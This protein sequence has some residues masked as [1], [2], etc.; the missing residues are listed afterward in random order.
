[1]ALFNN[2][3]LEEFL[4]FIRNCSTNLDLSGILEPGA[5]IQY[6][7]TMVHGESLRQFYTLYDELGSTALENLTTIILVLGT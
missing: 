2:N 7:R 3:D 6:L 1:M 5:K 4:L